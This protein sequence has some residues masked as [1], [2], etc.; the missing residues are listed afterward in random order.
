M[1]DHRIAAQR[2]AVPVILRWPRGLPAQ[3][4]ATGAL[5]SCTRPSCGGRRMLNRRVAS[6]TANGTASSGPEAMAAARGLAQPAGA[7]A[8]DPDS[9]GR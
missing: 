8:S 5:L 9:V 6:A 3:F 4:A 2:V 1:K 7:A